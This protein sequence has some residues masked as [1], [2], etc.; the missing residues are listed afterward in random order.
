MWERTI[1]KW[2]H[3]LPP[4]YTELKKLYSKYSYIKRISYKQYKEQ[5]IEYHLDKALEVLDG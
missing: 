3:E 1:E 2:D 4:V 5:K